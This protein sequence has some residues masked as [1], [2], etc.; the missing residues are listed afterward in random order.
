M[1][2]DRCK[3][4]RDAQRAIDGMHALRSSILA[5]HGE[6]VARVAQGLPV[7]EQA[8]EE[9]QGDVT[10]WY[11]AVMDSDDDIEIDLDD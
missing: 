11:D 5:T 10:V 4:Q 6:E 1:H 2:Y 3:P 8:P 7:A 9:S